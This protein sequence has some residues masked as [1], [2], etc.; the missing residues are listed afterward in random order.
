MNLMSDLEKEIG[1]SKSMDYKDWRKAASKSVLY[2]EF[3]RKQD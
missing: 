3:C 1:Q 2:K